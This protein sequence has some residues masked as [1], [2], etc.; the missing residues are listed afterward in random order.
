[1]LHRERQRLQS[2]LLSEDIATTN[3]LLFEV[4]QPNEEYGADEGEGE[5]SEKVK[6]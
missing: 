2:K 3:C 1:M 4:L 5:D 6:H